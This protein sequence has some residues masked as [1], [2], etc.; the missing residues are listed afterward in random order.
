MW[1]KLGKLLAKAAAWCL[2][3]PDKVVEIVQAVKK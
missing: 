2:G 3:N 1:A